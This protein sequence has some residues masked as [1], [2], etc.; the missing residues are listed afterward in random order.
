MRHSVEGAA[1]RW[2]RTAH[3]QFC[4]RN[5]AHLRQGAMEDAF[6]VT[7]QLDVFLRSDLSIWPILTRIDR[8]CIGPRP[9]VKPKMKVTRAG[10]GWVI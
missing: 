4:A 7:A 1:P 9:P 3:G 5:C 10:T 6:I 8:L 2:S